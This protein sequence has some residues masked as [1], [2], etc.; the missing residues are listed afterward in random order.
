MTT[1]IF[2]KTKNKKQLILF[3]IMVCVFIIFGCVAYYYHYDQEKHMYITKYNN[4]Q[5]NNIKEFFDNFDSH[6][7]K[8]KDLTTTNTSTSTKDILFVTSFVDIGREKWANLKRTNDDYFEW[9]NNLAKTITYP[10]LVLIDENILHKL[11]EK[12]KFENNIIFMDRNNVDTFLD[13][14]LDTEQAILDSDEFKRKIPKERLN[15]K[16]ETWNG[17]YNLMNHSK[18]NFVKYAKAMFPDYSYYSWIDFGYVR[19]DVNNVPQKINI[20]KLPKDKVV[21]ETFYLPKKQTEEEVLQIDETIFKGSCFII[22]NLLVETF[23]NKYENKLLNWYSRNISD[24]DES[25]VMQLY[26]DEPH[27]FN[28]IVDKDWFTL[29]RHFM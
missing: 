28:M 18:V 10:L 11:H 22:P 20:S 4:I 2:E 25:L 6:T 23:Y 12:Y 5:Y 9:F 16:P 14:Y 8:T 15:I 19:N 1:I 26:F 17:K 24:D 3:F 13:R 27:M 7:P 29:Y 21:F